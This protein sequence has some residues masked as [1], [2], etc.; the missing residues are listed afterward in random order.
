M[1]LSFR[2][3]CVLTA[4]TLAALPNAVRAQSYPRTL[5]AN[6]AVSGANGALTGTVTIHVDELMQDVDFKQVA[7]ALQ[8]QRLPAVPSCAAQAA[9]DWLRADRRQEDG[10]EVPRV[11]PGASP[12]LVLGT[13]RP[14][15]FVGGGAPDAKPRAGYEVGVIELDIDAK[16]NGKGTMAGAARVKRGPDGGPIVDDY[17]EAPIQLIVKPK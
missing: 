12:L 2:G 9:G 14:I 16:G 15:F 13:D 11:R 3:A 6:A 8:V 1:N 17:A 4:L 7:D 5:V 10:L